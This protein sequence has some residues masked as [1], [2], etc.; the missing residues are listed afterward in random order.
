MFRVRGTE[1]RVK[2]L[3][4]HGAERRRAGECDRIR[5]KVFDIENRESTRLCIFSEWASEWESRRWQSVQ[6][7]FGFAGMKRSREDDETDDA[8]GT[9]GVDVPGNEVA[10]TSSSDSLEDGAIVSAV[11]TQAKTISS[12]FDHVATVYGDAVASVTLKPEF[13]KTLKVGDVSELVTWVLTPD[14]GNPAWAF[15]RHKPKISRI[16]MVLA[17]GLCENRCANARELMPNIANFLGKGVPTNTDNGT[18]NELNVARTVLNSVRDDGPNNGLAKKRNGSGNQKKNE[19]TEKE[20]E[21]ESTD[22][23]S[24]CVRPF[25]FPPTHYVLSAQQMV[26]MDYPTPVVGGGD[27]SSG[28][29]DEPT[30]ILPDGF[31]VTQPSGAGIARSPALSMVALDCEMCYVGVG[32]DK[33]LVLTRCSVVG[34]DGTVVYDK[35][36]MPSEKITDYNTAHRYV[37]GLSQ[38]LTHCLPIQ[39]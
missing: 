14:G 5:E 10:G 23:A 27:D 25:P 17:P 8:C 18:A 38:I 31:V 16:V 12:S 13:A 15:V 19:K 34:P 36:V 2:K 33:R 21:T 24:L 9:T 30:L 11:P 35:L 29:K 37:L 3:V 6:V 28:D 32:V 20:T 22:A 39:Y 7:G 4:H 1:A 26:D